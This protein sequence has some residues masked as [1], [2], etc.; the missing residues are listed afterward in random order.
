MNFLGLIAGMVMLMVTMFGHILVV[1]GEYH[2]GTRLWPIFLILGISSILGSILVN[3]YFS[4]AFGILGFTF[5]WGIYELFR[6]KERVRRGW[7]P[8]KSQKNLITSKKD[9]EDLK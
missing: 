6:Q 4:V 7:F 2:L 3:N 5:L 1:K 9:R 8:K